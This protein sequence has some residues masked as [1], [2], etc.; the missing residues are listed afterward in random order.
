M[1]DRILRTALDWLPDINYAGFEFADR[2]ALLLLLLL[3]PLAWAWFGW[4]SRR[5]RSLDFSDLPGLVRVTGPWTRVRPHVPFVLRLAAL[6]LIA[7]ALARPRSG[8]SVEE[9]SSEG[10]DIIL[11]V[12]VS[13]SMLAEDLRRG[14]SRLDV[15]REVVTDF[16]GK[17]RHDRIGLVAFAAKALTRCPPTLDYRVLQA[18]VDNLKIGSI[19]DGTAIGV[20]LASSVNRLRTSRA[21]SRVIILLTDG[22]N[23]RGEVDPLTAAHVA[24]AEKVKVYTIGAG[25]RGVAPVPMM[26][27]FGNTR[28]VNQQVEIDE[29][30][31]GEIAELTGGR[32]YRATN[33]AE[34]ENIYREIDSL[35]KTKVE[36]KQYQRYDEL[37]MLLLVPALL[38]L[39][40]EILLA[41]TRF[42]TLP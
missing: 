10:I 31:L 7:L 15:A 25:T 23:N 40:I 18:Q 35:E 2:Y 11:T 41:R 27:Q 33:A 9:V 28:Y 42:G 32:Y 14:E 39:V 5:R 17:R 16:I 3:V 19:E 26:D 4:R 1:I 34:L 12:D 24:Q 37:F 29:K 20:A 22:M 21:K 30:T 13:T 36:V 38:L 8:S 6:A